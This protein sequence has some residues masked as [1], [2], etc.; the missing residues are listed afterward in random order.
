MKVQDPAVHAQAMRIMASATAFDSAE[1]VTVTVDG[2]EVVVPM[3]ASI[4]EAAQRAGR[5]IP[6][7][8]HHPDLPDAGV[9][10]VCVVEV[11]GQRNLQASCAFPITAPVDIKTYSPRVRQARRDI[12]DLMLAEHCGNCQTCGR[13]GNC[14]LQE[15]AAEYGSE[16]FRFGH[17]TEPTRRF[18]TF[19]P[20]IVRDMNKCVHCTRC[21][22]T[23]AQMQGIGALGVLGRGDSTTMSPYL[24]L[25]ISEVVC[26]SCGQCINRCPTGALQEVDDTQAV[27]AAIEDPT[28]HVVIQTA[29]APR[30]AIGEEFGLAPGTPVTWHLTTALKEMGFDKVFDT[31]F[32]ADLTII[33]EGTEL[34]A[35]LHEN[36]VLGDTRRPL[37]QFTSCSP[38]WIKYIEHRYPERLA[39][40]SSCKSP[41]QMFGALIKTWYAQANGLDP[42]DVVSVSL[43][44]CTAKKFESQRPEMTASGYADVDVA[45]TTRELAR[46]IHENGIHLPDLPESDFDDPFGTASGSGVIFGATGGV[47]EAAL[48]TVVELVTGRKVEELFTHAD[49]TPV[50]GFD[51]ARY[52]E[53]TL[54]AELGP[55]PPILAHLFTD[56][57]WLRGVTLKL[58]VVHGTANAT[59]V[60]DD[61][62]AGG[63]FAGCHFIEFMACPGGCLGGGG[64]PIPT[65]VT[66]RTARAQAIYGEDA[67][68]GQTGRVRKSHENPAVL[69]LYDELLTDGP[70][71]HTSHRLLHTQYTARGTFIDTHPRGEEAPC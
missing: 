46:M 36:L 1:T 34:L 29:P 44:P 63:L 55:V 56:W 32:S 50:R 58:A 13:N 69:R 60:M 45:L 28:K 57:D 26:V 51:G 53:I 70:C 25:P 40:L 23:C 7:L 17:R 24:G 61:I 68:Y 48:R 9:C 39:N 21:I 43:M 42:A 66:I 4:L 30:A 33:E 64:Q 35:R 10:R 65:D 3:G 6:T 22:R 14:E 12:V 67:R 11:S 5:R 16:T 71:G 37:P 38:G 54:P 59:R 2:R 20:S 52:A 19:G 49:I 27:W 41:Q 47:M 8:C 62:A 18:D 15:L 31:N